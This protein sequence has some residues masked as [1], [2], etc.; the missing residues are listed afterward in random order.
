[1]LV[2]SYHWDRRILV[3][4]GHELTKLGRDITLEDLAEHPL[5]TY[6]FSFGGQ[7][8]LKKAFAKKDLEPDVV[9]T[10]RD[11]DVIKTYVRMGLGVGIVASMADDCADKDLQSIEAKGLFPRSTT[12]IGY[13]KDAVL[14]RYMV[15]FMKLFAPH[16]TSRQMDDLR[17]AASQDA[18]DDMFGDAELPL[19]D[20]CGD[21]VTV[22]A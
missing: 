2:P 10:A 20:G 8:S 14:R 6:V 17:R 16:I 3:P 4:A 5:V 11:A 1:M 15:D 19:R 18:I 12:W 9:F 13:R 22:A 21:K 7:S